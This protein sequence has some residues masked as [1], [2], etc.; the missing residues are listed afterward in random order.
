MTTAINEQIKILIELQKIDHEHHKLKKELAEQP[1]LQKEVELAFEKKKAHLKAAED[2]LKAVQLKQKQKESDLAAREDKI[3]K[4]NSQLYAIKSNKEYTAMEMEIKG[5]KAD[6]SLLEEEIL[7]FFDTVEQA[8]T[9]VAKEKEALSGEEKKFK[10]ELEVLK[11]QAAGIEAQA[12]ELEEKRKQYTP[13]IEP[14]FLSQ[15][16]RLLKGLDGLALVPVVNNSCG[17][18]SSRGSTA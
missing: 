10:E 11:K 6:K 3:S 4:L 9:A 14:R 1:A 18:G 7:G 2:A 13:N 5:M 8:K 15:Y 12:K 17:G 16:E